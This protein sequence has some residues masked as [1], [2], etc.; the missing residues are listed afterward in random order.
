MHSVSA[1]PAE[2]GLKG[3]N[4][5]ENKNQNKLIMSLLAE[6][7]MKIPGLEEFADATVAASTA[8]CWG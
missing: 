7:F 2:Q 5:G 8:S 1:T 3:K 4:K 6:A